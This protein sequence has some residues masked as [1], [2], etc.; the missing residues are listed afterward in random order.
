M[1]RIIL[2]LIVM[3]IGL[4]AQADYTVTTY[5]PLYPAQITPP[6]GNYPTTQAYGQPYNQAY[7]PNPYQAQYQNQYQGQFVNPYQYRPN[8]YGNNLPY[9]ALNP[10]VTGLGTTGGSQVVKNIGQSVLYSL[11]RGY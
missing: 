1:N 6:V 2:A 8:V 7:Y 4:S 10:A 5:Q 11:L 9:S 3:T